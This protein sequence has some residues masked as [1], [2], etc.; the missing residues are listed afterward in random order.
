[1]LDAF[2]AAIE[3]VYSAAAGVVRWDD[4]LHAVEELTGS[5]ATVVHLI[6]RHAPAD[7]SL[8]LS[9]RIQNHY[10]SAALE[11]WSRE[12]MPLCPRLAAGVAQPDAPI[13]FDY[14]IMTEA[15]MD[16]DPVYDWY[17]KHGLRYFVGSPLGETT[18]YKF[19]W[20]LQRTP[21]QGHVNQHDMDL[22][23]LIK[24]H[25]ERALKLSEELGTLRC[26]QRF[27]A[28]MIEALPQA[29]FALD[30]KGR[31]IFANGA[32]QSLLA[33]ADGIVDA[34]GHLTI[35]CAAEQKAV[36]DLIRRASNPLGQVS[37][38]W[39][40]VSKPS[41]G[42]PLAVFVSPLVV[43]EDSLPTAQA[44]LLVVA[45]DTAH[46]HPV[47]LPM[48][49]SVYGL[50]DAESRLSAALSQGHSLESAAYKMAITPATARTHL[51]AIFN[52]LGVHRQQDLTRLLAFLSTIQPGA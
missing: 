25:V 26:Y 28:A 34:G 17:G 47:D 46:K 8:L 24:P 40:R 39:T 37:S 1:M 27:S 14:M 45:Y 44:K 29:I 50:T 12:L 15:E 22:F 35:S 36:D 11:E 9:G 30:G 42:L 7:S 3:K 18:R 52:K 16:R 33:K 41:G 4:A 38:G 49:K 19:M 2:N 51:K 13:V 21:A 32:G 5:A 48:L 20:S 23:A 31:L 10:D 43:H 6:D